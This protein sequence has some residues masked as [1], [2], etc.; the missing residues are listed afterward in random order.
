M[1]EFE[2][3]LGTLVSRATSHC[4]A[5][6]EILG[7]TKYSVFCLKTTY[8]V[9]LDTSADFNIC[10]LVAAKRSMIAED[11]EEY[12]VWSDEF[13]GTALNGS[14]WNESNSMSAGSKL[15]YANNKEF[16]GSSMSLYNLDTGKR[17]E[18]GNP[19]YSI[20]KGLNTINTMSYKYGRLEMRAK[21]PVG[22]GAFP[23]LWLSSRD[24]I[25][26]DIYSDYSTE[27]D[28]FEVFGKTKNESTAVAC[29]H[30]WYNEDGVKTGEECSCGTG[31]LA[32]NG[33]KVEES[34]RSTEIT[35]EWCTVVFEWTEDTMTFSINGKV[36][37]TARRNEMNYFD[38]S[39][40][41]TNSDGVF[42]QF[43][44]PILTNYMYTTG[45]GASYTYEGSASEILA[46]LENL[47]YEIDYIRLYQKNDGKSAINLQ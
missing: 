33:Y 39:G 17:D 41:D 23:A 13:N 26:Y 4:K 24:A 36:Y 25:G 2:F 12:L 18:N 16:D 15:E 45:E 29:I 19:T 42:N 6:I 9:N 14:V 10:D 5:H 34:D 43:M 44:Y 8:V 11:P 47:T 37:Y 27:V 22:A 35:Y 38:K 20:N 28:V 40:Y 46:N 21:I 30:K 7:K 31:V 1:E 3:K 32:G